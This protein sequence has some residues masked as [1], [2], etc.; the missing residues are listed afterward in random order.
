MPNQ[1][2]G[3]RVDVV[4]FHTPRAVNQYR[5]STGHKVGGSLAA[6]YRPDTGHTHHHYLLPPGRLPLPLRIFAARQRFEHTGGGKRGYVKYG[7]H[8]H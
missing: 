1:I 4:R 7:C 3:E 2:G 8:G 6:H 5:T